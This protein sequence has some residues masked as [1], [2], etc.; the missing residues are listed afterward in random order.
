MLAETRILHMIQLH[1]SVLITRPNEV[2]IPTLNHPIQCN[3][4][5]TKTDILVV[6]QWRLPGSHATSC[7][8]H[9]SPLVTVLVIPTSKSTAANI[10]NGHMVSLQ[11]PNE[12]LI[13]WRKQ[14]WN[15]WKWL[16]HSGS[17]EH[18][19]MFTTCHPEV[20][21][22]VT[23]RLRC[24]RNTINVVGTLHLLNGER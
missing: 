3:Y 1:L 23:R 12:T 6:K 4:V 19:D 17:A 8:H 9:T 16:I 15:G 24:N 13:V 11:C 20:D 18:D 2:E 22:D 7:H 5:K 14:S 21:L 10:I